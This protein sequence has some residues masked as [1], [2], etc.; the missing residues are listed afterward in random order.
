MIDKGEILNKHK[1]TS[2]GDETPFSWKQMNEDR[3]DL[4]DMLP[5]YNS[6]RSGVAHAE[7]FEECKAIVLKSLVEKLDEFNEKY[8]NANDQ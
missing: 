8:T 1:K 3:E 7:T 6:I 5:N 4:L 2:G